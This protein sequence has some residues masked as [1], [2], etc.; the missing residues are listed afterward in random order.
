MHGMASHLD[1]PSEGH[2][3][4]LW[5]SCLQTKIDCILTIEEL[6]GGKCQQTLEGDVTIGIPGLGRIAERIICSSLRDVYSGIP[7]IVERCVGVLRPPRD[8]LCMRVQLP[9]KRLMLTMAPALCRWNLVRDE[10]LQQ[11]D[12]REVL[13]N[14]RPPLQEDWVSQQVPHNPLPSVFSRQLCEEPAVLM[15]VMCTLI[16]WH[17]RCGPLHGCHRWLTFCG[18]RT[19]RQPADRPVCRWNAR[20]L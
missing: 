3:N 16:L 13:F 9:S 8:G 12:G 20:L 4:L 17:L 15:M 19:V 14:G 11:P 6:E 5:W 18:A 1:K 2:D 7:E 10:V